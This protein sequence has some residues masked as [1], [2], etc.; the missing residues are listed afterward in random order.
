[1]SYYQTI[2]QP[3]LSTV[4]TVLQGF[5]VVVP[6]TLVGIFWMG[7]PGVCVAAVVSEVLTIL[8][9]ALY[10]MG[11][12]RAGRFPGGG[13]YMLPDIAEETCLDFSIENHLEDVIKLR[14]ALFDFCK[15]NGIG[16]RMRR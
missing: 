16:E 10:R 6:L 3:G 12:Q 7:L 13:R 11:G 5:G 1:M 15:E 2:L 8:V 14:D 4:I 9:S